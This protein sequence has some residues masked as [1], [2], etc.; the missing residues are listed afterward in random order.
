MKQVKCPKCG[1]VQ[2][3]WNAILH[4][5]CPKCKLWIK[6]DRLGRVVEIE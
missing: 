5:W 1:F 3:T 6:V 2:E 4:W